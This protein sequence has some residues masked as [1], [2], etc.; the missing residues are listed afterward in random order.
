MLTHAGCKMSL[1]KV[2]EVSKVYRRKKGEPVYAVDR[3]S[4]EVKQGQ[5]FG[6]LGPNGEPLCESCVAQS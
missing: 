4:F 2:E 1:I 3:V 6:L 5:I